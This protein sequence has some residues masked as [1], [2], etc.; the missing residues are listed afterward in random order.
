[1]RGGREEGE[2]DTAHLG[3]STQRRDLKSGKRW[4]SICGW[5]L[6]SRLFLCL[7]AQPHAS[8]TWTGQWVLRKW[9]LSY[10]ISLRK[11]LPRWDSPQ[12]QPSLPQHNDATPAAFFLILWIFIE[13]PECVLLGISKKYESWPLPSKGLCLSAERNGPTWTIWRGAQGRPVFSVRMRAWEGR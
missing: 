2:R 11:T 6:A 12:T 8:A 4:Q 5:M 7:A 9:K 10:N 13:L 1:M 3:N